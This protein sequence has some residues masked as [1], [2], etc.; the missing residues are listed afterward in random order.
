MK[1]AIVAS[2]AVPYVK[3]GGLA[4]VIG[5]LPRY[6]N[7][8]GIRTTIF[9]PKYKGIRGNFVKDIRLKMQKVYT[10]KIFK[11]GDFYFIDYPDFFQRDGLY[12]TKDGD[13]S[14][15]FERFTLFC[16]AV[17]QLIGEGNYDIVH[18]HDWQSALIPLY[19]KLNKYNVKS[20]F[21]IHNLGYQGKF[22]GSKFPLLDIEEN[23]FSP[24]G[25]ECCG[26]INF[27]KAG[28]LYSDVIT[29]V[30]ENYAR[31]IQT[32]E[33]GFQLDGVLKKRSND[34]YGIINGIDYNLWNPQTDEMIYH[35]YS[36]FSGK[37]KNKMSLAHENNIDTKRPIIGM[38]SR[39][40]GQKGFDLLTKVLDE[41][42]EMGFSFVLLGSG[43]EN[44]C[45]KLKAFAKIYANSVSIN[46]KFDN[47]LAHRIYAGSDF[48]L[49]PSFYE[50]CGL[51]QL[52]SLKYGSVP[53][54]RKTGG[55]ADTI[56]E[57]DHKKMSGNGFLFEDYSSQA[58]IDAISRAYKVYCN[59][60]I[61]KMLSV[62]CMEYNFSWEE[63]AKKYKNLYQS[64]LKT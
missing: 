59:K 49:M 31:E 4:D 38:V 19:T 17:T 52:I 29:T 54:V 10:A 3:S 60:E 11:D 51:G 21:T 28:I 42:I 26:N 57:F 24:E 16:K 63:S 46:I 53:I 2:E 9:L 22:P 32:P 58:L 6:L 45:A 33:L 50:P 39:I 40:A 7:K 64:L 48:F 27:L 1:I 25:I 35:T 14:D 55:L 61:F 41:I 56:K 62:K 13:F 15:N 43:E 34:I 20:I 37:M 5:A 8:L 30:S 12:G 23:Y 36:D 47:K 18:C 44:Y